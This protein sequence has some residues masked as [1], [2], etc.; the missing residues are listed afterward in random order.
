MY[1]R[2]ARVVFLILLG[3]AAASCGKAE[4]PAPPAP[5][6]TV[7]QPLQKDVV[8]WDDFVGRFEAVDQVDIRPRVSGYL[9]SIGFRDGEVVRKGQVLFVIDPRPYQAAVDQARAQATRAQATLANAK[10]ALDRGQVLLTARAISQEEFDV[11]QAAQRQAAAD[12]A[13]AQANVRNAELNLGFTRV[14]A[15]LS[16]RASDRRVAVGNL[17]NADGTVLTTVV[18]LNPIRFAFD[19]SEALYLKYQRDNRGGSRRS[20]RDASNPVLIR[21]QD[22]PEYRWKGRMDFVDNALNTGSGTIRGRAVVDNPGN[23]LTPGMFGHLRLLGSAPYRAF[24]V[25]DQAVIADQ[26][27]QIVYILGD[28]GMVRQQTVDPGPVVDGLRVVRAGLK[29]TDK[30]IIDGLQRVRPGVK[31]LGAPGKIVLQPANPAANGLASTPPPAAS[32]T[33]SEAR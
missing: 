14:V 17:V 29:P 32:A 4:K 16:G 22:E 27:S 6:V 25:P 33:V 31:A 21:L 2:P 12:L 28:D 1:F 8:D 19:G 20:S 10:T 26:T 3:L 15:P 23:F 13:A 24:L 7:A 30:V 9:Q 11:R 18:S 5:T